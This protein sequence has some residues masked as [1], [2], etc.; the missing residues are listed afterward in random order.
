MTLK[1]ARFRT[2]PN[3]K[4]TDSLT[5]VCVLESLLLPLLCRVL[6]NTKRGKAR[7]KV[8]LDVVHTIALFAFTFRAMASTLVAMASNLLE[9]AS[10]LI[11]I[12]IALLAFTF[13]WFTLRKRMRPKPAKQLKHPARHKRTSR[14]LGSCD[15]RPKRRNVGRLASLFLVAMPGAPSSVL[16]PTGKWEAERKN[17]S[18]HDGKMK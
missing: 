15:Q 16:A 12:D 10:N 2:C 4:R 8:T 9:M 5:T 11:A 14:C 1:K 6:M 18:R 17:K 3:K 13:A 7:Q